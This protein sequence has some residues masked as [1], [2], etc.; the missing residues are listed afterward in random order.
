MKVLLKL[1]RLG[2]NMDEGVIA[3]W[4]VKAGEAFKKD[5]VLYTVETEKAASD[6][7]AP[8]DGVM[9]E[10]LHGEGAAVPV[11]EHVCVIDR[12]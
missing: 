1:P 5:Q 8:C 7:E 10:V 3:Q 2:M 9:L 11:G 12:V 4:H 6:V